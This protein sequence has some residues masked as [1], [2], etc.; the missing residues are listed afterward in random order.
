MHVLSRLAPARRLRYAIVFSI[1]AAWLLA[2]AGCF[3]LGFGEKVTYVSETPETQ[4]RISGLEA[5]IERMEQTLQGG[6]PIER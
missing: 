4:A 1:C 6:Q 3:S 2:T 5:R